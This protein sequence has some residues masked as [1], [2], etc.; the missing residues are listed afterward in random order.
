MRN[1]DMNTSH[2][3]KG[4]GCGSEQTAVR[5]LSGP[6]LGWPLWTITADEKRIQEA[7][8]EAV[9]AEMAARLSVR[10]F[11][12]RPLDGRLGPAQ[13]FRFENQSSS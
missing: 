9:S 2:S 11:A 1:N 5:A 12:C 6:S 10:V 8:S 3:V 7:K 4:S 13:S